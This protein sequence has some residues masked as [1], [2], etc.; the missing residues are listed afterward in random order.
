MKKLTLDRDRILRVLIPVVYVLPAAASILT[1]ILFSM[2]RFAY[3]YLRVE[4]ESMGIFTLVK[5]TWTSCQ[6][7]LDAKEI[8]YEQALFSYAMIA[9]SIVFW[10]LLVVYVFFAI[11]S[12]ACAC[13]AFASKPTSDRANLAKKLF[14]FVC[15]NRPVYVTLQLIPILLA[16]FPY[17]LRAYY[18][19][20]LGMAMTLL[21]HGASDLLVLFLAVALSL[22]AYL[23]TLPT[24]RTLHLDAFR[25]YKSRNKT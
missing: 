9:Y 12:S 8:P 16:T 24:Q 19:S 13:V 6:A 11:Y 3:I 23:L 25:L 20:K 10:V 15:F 22:L 4:H 21:Y 18:A 2:P 7:T 1:L 14:V 5:N 17:I